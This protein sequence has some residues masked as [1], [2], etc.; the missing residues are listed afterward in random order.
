MTKHNFAMERKRHATCVGNN[1]INVSMP[2]N[3]NKK[4][5]GQRT[6]KKIKCDSEQ[7]MNTENYQTSSGTCNL[8]LTSMISAFDQKSRAEQY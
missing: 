6:Y 4:G 5:K 1:K 3:R 2:S 8:P 7:P